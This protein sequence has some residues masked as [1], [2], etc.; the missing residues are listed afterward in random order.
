MM[1]RGADGS[2]G[3]GAQQP[4]AG[5]AAS[6]RA[7]TA[8]GAD[9]ELLEQGIADLQRRDA[10]RPLTSAR[11]S[12]SIASAS[13]RSTQARDVHRGQPRRARDRRASSTRERAAG[14]VRGPLH[15]IPILLKDNIDT[16]DRMTTTAGSL[17]LD[18]SMPARDA[19]V[20]ARAARGRRGHPRQD[21]PERVGQLPLDPL[22]ERLE[23]AR[24]AD[25]QPLRPRPQPVRLELGLGRGGA[26]NLCAVA[27]GTETDGSIVCP[28]SPCGL[29]GIKPT[30]RPGQPRR[31]SS[32]SRTARTPPGRWRAPWPTPRPCCRRARRRRPARPGDDG[33]PGAAP[34]DYT[35]FL[36]PGR[37]AGARIGVAR[38]VLRLPRAASTADARTR[39]PLMSEPAP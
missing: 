3:Q 33:A 17:A 22:V 15:G 28:S 23:R 12:S 14:R 5:G 4:P 30:R 8:P 27:I 11:A 6:P 1:A 39:S 9:F 38:E 21:E 16:A 10:A 13:Q 35:A 36:D 31:A 19:S 20:V 29:V 7:A 34:T 26:A 37:C 32:R 25:P 2:P 18:G 24:R